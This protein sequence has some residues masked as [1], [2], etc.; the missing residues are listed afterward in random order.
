LIER[1]NLDRA[2]KRAYR[3]GMDKAIATLEEILRAT[4]FQ[5][6]WCQTNG[7]PFTAQVLQAVRENLTSGG[8][9]AALMVPW[10]GNPLADALVLRA[11]GALHLMVRTCRAPDLAAFY[12]GH[13][14][15]PWDP[16]AAGHAIESAV[17]THRTFVEDVI[18]RPPQTNET[19]RSAVLMPGYAEIARRTGLPLSIL[20]IGASA[21]LNLLWDRYAYRYG[22]RFVGDPNAPVTIEADWRGPWCNVDRLPKVVA[23]RGCDRDPFDLSAPGAAD[24]LIAYVWPE[25]KARLV[26]IE[27][28]IALAQR[29][30]PPLEKADAADWLERQLASR[31]PNAATVVAHTIVW[32]YIAKETRQ[33][34]EALLKSTGDRATKSAPLAWLSLEQYAA[35]QLPEVRLTLWP[36][37]ETK[38]IAL[39]HPH[40]AWIEWLPS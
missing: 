39:A 13:G 23:K 17:A 35:D 33:K 7:A 4:D 10:S 29:E 16:A 11:T 38:K 1:I 5:I 31:I 8:T 2:P 15:K 34:I 19:G 25:Q 9:L 32:Q 24:R 3:Q 28:A 6:A 12:P 30:K 20:E 21:G 40:G 37:G 27:A 36:G 26:R 14:G 18:S 22:D